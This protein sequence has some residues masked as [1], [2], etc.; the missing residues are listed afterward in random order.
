MGYAD[1]DDGSCRIG[2][3]RRFN[4]LHEPLAQAL[5]IRSALRNSSPNQ[6]AKR[7]TNRSLRNLKPPDDPVEPPLSTSRAYLGMILIAD[8]GVFNLT[9]FRG[10]GADGGTA[11][12]LDLL[13]APL[14]RV[15]RDGSATFDAAS[16]CW[17]DELAMSIEDFGYVE[18]LMLA[19]RL[20]R[21]GSPWP[22]GEQLVR[23]AGFVSAPPLGPSTLDRGTA[24]AVPLPARSRNYRIT[25]CW[26]A[27]PLQAS[28]L[29]CVPA[30]PVRTSRHLPLCGLTTW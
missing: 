17:R 29:A 4:R 2:A 19:A 24:G 3:G 15:K 11:F 13:G 12:E 20:A 9:P 1:L 18:E 7:I 28:I 27:L 22:F 8:G 14:D 10:H 21:G 26:P 30:V 16:A 23:I 6:Q 5:R 25:Q